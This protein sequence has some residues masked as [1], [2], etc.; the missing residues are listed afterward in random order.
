MKF[1]IE[2]LKDKI[3]KEYGFNT[4][5]QFFEYFN[6]TKPGRKILRNGI[7]KVLW[8]VLSLSNDLLVSPKDILTNYESKDLDPK[9]KE[10]WFDRR[11]E[12]YEINKKTKRT[13]VLSFTPIIKEECVDCASIKIKI[14]KVRKQRS[15]GQDQ[16]VSANSLQ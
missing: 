13:P 7:R 2:N 8:E 1:Q 16:V 9:E 4:W 11:R 15:R 6:T 5:N 3:A 10:K 14:N 12:L